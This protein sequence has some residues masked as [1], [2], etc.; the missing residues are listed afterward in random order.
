M[1]YSERM[2]RRT[3]AVAHYL[4]ARQTALPLIEKGKMSWDSPYLI[5]MARKGIEASQYIY[6]SAFRT[7]YSNTSLGRVMTRFHPYAWNS[8]KRRRNLYK[9]ANYTKFLM[10]TDAQQRFS[11]QFTADL[12]SMALASIFVGTIFEYALSP[13]MS[14]MQDTSQWLFGS[15]EDRQKAFF[16]AW[17]HTSLAPLQVVTPPISRFVLAPAS[18][19]LNG[20]W[21]N[22]MKYQFATWVPAG[23]LL[24]DGYR[25]YQSPSMG[26]DFLSGIPLHR[27]GQEVKKNRT[28]VE[29]DIDAALSE[30]IDDDS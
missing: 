13:P 11:R 23:R 30:Q 4:N 27:I 20:E 2:L 19:L 1:Q 22:F 26:F 3:A 12:M 16:S 28:Q 8:V 6:H 17:P 25:T 15:K 7:N 18:A 10:N 29:K 14:W 5:E 21:D 9:E 24:R